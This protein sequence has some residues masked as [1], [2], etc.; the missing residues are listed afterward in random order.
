MRLTQLHD[1]PGLTID[2]KL[3]RIIDTAD[4][5]RVWVQPKYNGVMGVWNN[6]N[7]WTRHDKKYK[8]GAF[9]DAFYKA[10][11]ILPQD[12]IVYGELTI[13]GI[14]FQD[15]VG[16][17][18]VS[19]IPIGL[20]QAKFIVHDI[21]DTNRF[22]Q[23]QT[24]KE[25]L[26][27]LK[28]LISN[29]TTTGQYLDRSQTYG[30]QT[31][32]EIQ[33]FFDRITADGGEGIVIRAEP[34]FI[35]VST[36]SPQIIKWKKTED[37]EGVCVSVYEGLG[38]LKGTLGGFTLR[39]VSGAHVNVGGGKGLNDTMRDKLWAKPPI[40]KSITFAYEM[41]SSAGIP[42]KPQFLSVRDYE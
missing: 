41:L 1:I 40:G 34:A 23:E 36:E 3:K 20:D 10:L 28:K 2:D 24:Y 18:S 6:G 15:A 9:C 21:F 14:P 22:V 37:A 7:M 35:C 8:P 29:E 39:L 42:L 19:R 25:R 13:P 31:R 16:L 30:V 26:A 33:D 17:L 11:S 4:G 5:H 32:H 12:H 27:L 38:K